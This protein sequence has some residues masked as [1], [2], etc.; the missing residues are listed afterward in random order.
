ME[1]TGSDPPRKRERSDF[2]HM[3]PSKR[4]LMMSQSGSSN[5]PKRSSPTASKKN[6]K[7]STSTNTAEK[8][9][10]NH[11]VKSESGAP[12]VKRED[13][14]KLSS[15]SV[16]GLEDMPQDATPEEPEEWAGIDIGTHKKKQLVLKI[17]F[18]KT[19]LQAAE[20]R[21]K[22]QVKK[23]NRLE[24]A[25]GVIEGHWESLSMDLL[26]QYAK[27][28]PKATPEDL[29]P[30]KYS[31]AVSKY[32]GE[33]KLH[34]GTDNMR[35]DVLLG[36]CTASRDL[37]AQ[38]IT[39]I[40]EQSLANYKLYEL[41]REQFEDAEAFDTIR[42]DNEQLH[43]H[44]RTLREQVNAFEAK[45]RHAIE[46][47]HRVREVTTAAENGKEGYEQRIDTLLDEKET[48]YRQVRKLTQ[49]IKD[50]ADA[51]GR[52][53]DTQAKHDADARAIKHDNAD[54]DTK[55][56][57]TGSD[58]A[59]LASD[60]MQQKY[61]DALQESAKRLA[62]IEQLRTERS[63][64]MTELDRLRV[65][66]VPE[67]QI[68]GSPRYRV[69][70]AQ[71]AAVSKQLT[72]LTRT[73]ER[74]QTEVQ[75]MTTNRRT[76]FEM[77][78]VALMDL[79]EK[80]AKEILQHEQEMA[81][82]RQERDKF[83]RNCEQLTHTKQAEF[84]KTAT[85]DLIK[86][87]QSAT[88]IMM[89]DLQKTR[90][91]KEKKNAE[92]EDKLSKP[93]STTNSNS[94]D[95]S[96]A[97]G[98][99]SASSREIE[100]L[101]EQLRIEKN[102]VNEVNTLLTV[103][104]STSK[105]K[106]STRDALVAERKLIDQVNDLKK[107]LYKCKEE[108]RDRG[109]GKLDK[110]TE[111]ALK[112]TI[113]DKDEEITIFMN[114]ME[115]IS[116]SY[117]EVQEHNVRLLEQITNLE[118]NNVVLLSSMN[119]TEASVKLLNE[120]KSEA[121]NKALQLKHTVDT[122]HALVSALEERIKSMKD[123]ITILEKDSWTKQQALDIHKKKSVEALQAECEV[124]LLLAQEKAR[125]DELDKLVQTKNEEIQ[126]IEHQKNRLQEKK[127][128]LEKQ[129][130]RTGPNGESDE[131]SERDVLE[132]EIKSLKELVMCTLCKRRKKNTMLTKCQ[133]VFCNVCITDRY[134]S[135]Q[136]KCPNC[137][138]PFGAKDITSMYLF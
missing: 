88:N 32:I 91:S 54:V 36:K 107:R 133:H 87:M 21:Y 44:N 103:Y 15:R 126:T 34:E 39:Q 94:K 74:A 12:G 83:R 92:L 37:V 124:K 65:V 49:Q 129:L 109:S 116:K 82:C 98:S 113:Q 5:S 134:E 73:Y 41:L 118:D 68:T 76:D 97:S 45:T 123:Q 59:T 19:E 93:T 1:G 4:A 46:E 72:D 90:E 30:D 138:D 86:S 110:A 125:A 18:Q 9:D 115:S 33:L 108:E 10:V 47:L 112:Q 100:K 31:N 78:E 81:L 22:M 80:H 24:H 6:A 106:D 99:A 77:G 2:S 137:L 127:N 104:K 42:K 7:N 55:D 84:T 35:E 75:Q 16:T 58:T 102:K 40:E 71:L 70:L 11:E 43:T 79:R 85:T 119:K 120:A 48:L 25:V 51:R 130:N 14:V 50:D 29:E 105:L 135:R 17:G 8:R 61:T 89:S 122:S 67:K 20:T 63:K 26:A 64:I 128:K 3:P 52:E 136:R 23:V 66:K 96:R 101:Q 117:Y 28:N 131:V 56:T 69:V 57:K 132:E 111:K 121:D 13:R 38:I 53:R 60:E 62:E 95:Q 114:E 27:I